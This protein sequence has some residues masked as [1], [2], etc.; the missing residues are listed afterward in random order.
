MVLAVIRH[1]ESIE[2][3][4]KYNGFYQDRRPWDGRAAHAISRNIVGLTP[5]G[6]RQS[7]WL[8]R[9][10]AELTGMGRLRVLTSTYRR[11]IDTADVAFTAWPGRCER[12]P[13][14]DEQHYGDATYMTKAELFATYPDGAD[15]RRQRKHLWVPS[16][17]GGVMDRAR[18]FV[19]LAQAAVCGGQTVV[20]VTH[21]TTILALRCLL[22]DRPLTDVVDEP[23]RAKTPNAGIC[24][25]QLADGR[26][27]PIGSAAPPLDL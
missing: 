23:R 7:A 11:S 14:L 8:G 27:E 22:E 20:A 19:D 2:N 10:L 9:E 1:A 15:G 26:F 18:R 13:L 24:R 6:F 17:A 4:D 25:Y 3:A 12:T 16:L 5:R 21:H